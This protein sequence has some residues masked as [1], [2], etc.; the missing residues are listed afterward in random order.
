MTTRLP[1]SAAGIFG[2]LSACCL[3]TISEGTTATGGGTPGPVPGVFTLAGNGTRGFVDGTGGPKGTTEFEWPASLAVD[4]QG[5]VYVADHDD[6][7]I[8]KITPDGTTTTLAGNGTPGFFDGSGGADGT[9][10]LNGPAGVAVDSQGNVYVVD[11]GN[12]RVRKIDPDGMTTT[13]AGNGIPGFFDGSGG[14]NGT[15]EFSW[16]AN[17][18]NPTGLS[19][20]G[21]AVDGQGFSYVADTCNNRLR[22]IAPDG[23]TTTLLGNG[24][25]SAS[26][27]SDP[28]T[29]GFSLPSGIA[30]DV[31]GNVYF[32]SFVVGGGDAQPS[33]NRILKVTADGVMTTLAGN[34]RPGYADGSASRAEFNSPL[35][36]AVDNQGNVVVADWGNAS[37]REVAP[38]GTT[39]T[40][41]GRPWSGPG[42]FIP[43]KDGSGWPDGTATFGQPYGVAVDL[44]GIVYVADITGVIRK[45]VP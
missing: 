2:L 16:I 13:L 12:S 22:K 34:G 15:T 11:T 40:L 30:V 43:N 42:T 9:T 19:P 3:Q 25:G 45:I 33:D 37:I 1:L 31:V 18:P 8:R 23:T 20:M 17:G 10:E 24:L 44:E 27:G 14:P 21:I 36:V 39:T 38:D 6:N 26:C 32:T 35:G 41:A 4:G 28:G 5:N 29:T 7:R